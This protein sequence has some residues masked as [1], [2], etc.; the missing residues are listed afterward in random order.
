MARPKQPLTDALREAIAASGLAH[1][2]IERGTGVKRQ[3]ILYFM[4]GERSLRLDVAD[5]LAA[6]FGL[7]LRPIRPKRKGR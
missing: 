2:A 4:R 1:I 3:S 5:K 6:F 7:G